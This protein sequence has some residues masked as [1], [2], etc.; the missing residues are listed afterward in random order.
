MPRIIRKQSDRKT[1]PEREIQET[2]GSIK[3]RLKYRQKIL[4]I[5]LIAF[6]VFI[7]S[8]TG[9]FLYN[10]SASNKASL[11]E[12]EGYK[13][14][15]GQFQTE[16]D[17][18]DDRYKK[19]LEK[20]KESY[21]IKKKPNVLFYIA[22]CYY[23]MGNYDESIKTLKELIS[24]FSEPQIVSFSYYKMANAY[25]KKNDVENALSSLKSLSKLKDGVLQDLALMEIGKILE[26]TGRAEEAK[27]T[28]KELIEKHPK[29]TFVN[30][31][32]A[33]LEEK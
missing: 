10:K 14:Y 3:E 23:E 25:L 17:I 24:R 27:E 7:G 9:F 28:Y 33:R 12:Y 26:A 21:N 19:A 4:V 18:S 13:I 8:V 5:S 16:P 30:E 20:F 15:Y 6:I 11:L 22:N 31:A 29:S 2:I 1:T 32:K